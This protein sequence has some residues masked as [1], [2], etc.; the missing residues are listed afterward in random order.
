MMNKTILM[1]LLT[2]TILLSGCDLRDFL[3]IPTVGIEQPADG[4]LVT[5]PVYFELEAKNWAIEPP[6]M[7]RDGAG[8]FVIILEGGCLPAGRLVPFEGP[9]VHLQDGAFSAWI[10]LGPGTYEVCV[11]V[12]DGNHRALQLTEEVRFEVVD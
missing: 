1:A 9:F 5:N 11:Q 12:A 3:P 8:Y 10:D 2:S 7:R 4:S 6:V